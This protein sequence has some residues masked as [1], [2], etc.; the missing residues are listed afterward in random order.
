ML[1]GGFV[2]EDRIVTLADIDVPD[3]HLRR[4][5]RRDRPGAGGARDPPRRAARR[6][7]RGGAAR[8]ALRARRRLDGD[9]RRPGRRSPPGRAGATGEGELPERRPRGSA[10]D[11]PEPDGARGRRRGSASALE[12]AGRRRQ[13][14]SP[15]RSPA[16]RRG[17]IGGAAGAR[18][19][20]RPASCRA[21]RGWAARAGHADLARA[22]ARRAGARARPRPSSSCSR[23]ARYSH[24]AVKRA[25]RQRRARPALARRPPGRARRRADEH[26]AERARRSSRR[27]TGSARSPC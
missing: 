17:T 18:P 5:G 25:D 3:P 11:E 4:R 26:P 2:I 8:R 24:E 9:P 20:R 15:A 23:T 1:P 19:R 10:T 13:R 7:L 22:A 14:R 27:S 12:L 16:P 21:W 6:R